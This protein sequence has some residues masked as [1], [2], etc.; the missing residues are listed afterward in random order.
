MYEDNRYEVELLI[1][2]EQV[3][4]T[5]EELEDEEFIMIIPFLPEGGEDDAGCLVH[6]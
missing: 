4:L 5:L 6:A 3:I 2:I 1:P